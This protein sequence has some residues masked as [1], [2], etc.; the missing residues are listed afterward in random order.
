MYNYGRKKKQFYL[1]VFFN[2]FFYFFLWF[3][4]LLFKCVHNIVL[5]DN[6]PTYKMS[7]VIST[8]SLLRVA[9]AYFSK[10]SREDDTF[11][12]PSMY[13]YGNKKT[14]LSFSFFLRFF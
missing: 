7:T 4:F 3:L 1:V 14:I 11:V 8:D 9:E 10:D 13:N 12:F 2:D 5:R 6:L